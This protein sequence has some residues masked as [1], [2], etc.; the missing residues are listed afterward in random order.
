MTGELLKWDTKYSVGVDEIDAQHKEL[1]DFV[2]DL[3]NHSIEKQIGGNIYIKKIIDA[4]INH[5]THHF[6]TEEKLLAKTSYT[7]LAEHKKEHEKIAARVID[8]R[9]EMGNEKGDM[10]LYSL[11]VTLREYFLIHIVQYDKEACDFFKEGI[12]RSQG[13]ADPRIPNRP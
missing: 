1:L 10:A 12:G 7:K 6:S 9:R 2:N 5:V 3:I 13:S 4:I 8:L 11:T